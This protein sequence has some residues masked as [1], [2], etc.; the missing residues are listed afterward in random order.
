[1]SFFSTLDLKITLWIQRWI[2][3][4]KLSWVLSRINRGEFLALILIPVMLLSE[5]Y[6]PSWISIPYILLFAYMTDRMVLSLKKFF[7]RKR[8]LV[9]VMGK[10]DSNPD[11]KHSFPSA[12]SANSMVV[13]TILVFAFHESYLVFALSLFAGIGRL[14]TLHHF[15]SDILGGWAIGLLFG[16]FG[17]F[18]YLTWIQMLLV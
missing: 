10:V 4:P 6:R 7:S 16:L 9:S 8:P 1:M 5:K 12:H 14:I 18:I 15:L 17:S 3:N 13:G 2:H 11:M